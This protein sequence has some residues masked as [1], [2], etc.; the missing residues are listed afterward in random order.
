M[1]AHRAQGVLR[2]EVVGVQPLDEGGGV[3]PVGAIVIGANAQ[4]P[5]VGK[6]PVPAPE[7]AAAGEVAAVR[8]PADIAF[9]DIGEQRHLVARTPPLSAQACLRVPVT[10]SQRATVGALR[11]VE[12]ELLGVDPVVHA[13]AEACAVAGGRTAFLVAGAEAHQA[14]LRFARRPGDDV[15]HAIDGVRSPERGAGP[16]DHLDAI[17]VLEHHVLALPE[18]AGKQR[19]V[20]RAPVDEDQHLV[21]QDV[22]KPR[23]LIA[24]WA[25]SARATWRFG[26]SRRASPR[27]VAPARWMSCAEITKIEVD[28]SASRSRRRTPRSR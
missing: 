18:D 23:A 13:F 22:L 17:D 15:D 27:V 14:A 6:L 11:G 2:L 8:D 3:V 9:V 7:H 21:G 5:T 26:A 4:R 20:D 12:L 28:T 1:R 16:A 25:V 19:R 10:I 24:Y